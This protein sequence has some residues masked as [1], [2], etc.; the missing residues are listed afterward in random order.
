M[1]KAHNINPEDFKFDCVRYLNMINKLDEYKEHRYH[2]LLH[3]LIYKK[4][5]LY[6]QWIKSRL[7]DWMKY[8]RGWTLG[9]VGGIP[10]GYWWH[11][12]SIKDVVSIYK[13]AVRNNGQILLDA[14]ECKDIRYWEKIDIDFWEKRIAAMRKRKVK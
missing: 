7:T 8:Y 3:K 14:D 2:R 5:F 10:D 6:R 4:N 9:R 11:I 1:A 12:T 13:A